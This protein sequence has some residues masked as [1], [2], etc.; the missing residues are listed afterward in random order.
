M[1]PAK[2]L[3]VLICIGIALTVLAVLFAGALS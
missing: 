2:R 1:S 3:A